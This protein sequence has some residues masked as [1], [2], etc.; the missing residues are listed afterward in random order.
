MAEQF[1]EYREVS[2]TEPLRQGDVLEA[3]D[4]STPKWQRHLLVITAD[5]D[6]AHDKHAGRVT[7]VPILRAD[8]YLLE[9]QVPRLA[10]KYISGK[11][12]PELRR[13]LAK[14]ATPNISESRLR[15]WPLETAGDQI[16]A[17][18]ELS[19]KD[20]EVAK[21]A[22]GAL[23]ILGGESNSLDS[24]ITA[25]VAAQLA[26]PNPQ[27]RENV[28]RA[29]AEALK[30]PYIHPPGDAMFLSAIGSSDQEGYFVYLRH[31]EQLWESQIAIA[32]LRNDSGYRRI[33]RIRERYTHALVQ[34]FA[35]VFMAIGL[36]QEYEQIRDLYSD[37]LG[38]GIQ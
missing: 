12:L 7:C 8:E 13:I 21:A 11:L 2:S 24:A 18:L 6:F 14:S 19:G 37:N 17:E 27:K 36:P 9:M 16:V 22:F 20:G 38:A 33:S 35:L 28:V 10:E 23:S 34:R 25:L 31:L 1:A 26:G 3:A 30:G 32:P 5:C 29:V 4:L 15:T